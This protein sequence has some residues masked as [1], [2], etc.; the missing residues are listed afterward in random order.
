MGADIVEVRERDAR[1]PIERAG[2]DRILLDAPC[3][4]LGTL[5]SRPDARWRKNPETIV[6]LARL[7]RELLDAASLQLR[8][9]GTLVYSTCTISEAE[10]ERQVE[11]FLA[12]RPE[13]EADDLG[14]EQ[15]DLARAGAARFL[16]LFPHRDRTDGFFIARMRRAG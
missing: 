7:Q 14:A 1:E 3:T 12:D 13:L 15:P 8:P 2:F 11:A 10:N 9:G 4:D 16:Q 6:E 5:Q